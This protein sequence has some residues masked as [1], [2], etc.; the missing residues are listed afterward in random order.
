MQ[1]TLLA[2]LIFLNKHSERT[3]IVILNQ[4]DTVRRATR[5]SNAH[6]SDAV[7][8]IHKLNSFLFCQY[9]GDWLIDLQFWII[10]IEC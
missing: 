1:D 6:G 5:S 10:K 2:A 3:N 7:M 8:M 9:R 4:G